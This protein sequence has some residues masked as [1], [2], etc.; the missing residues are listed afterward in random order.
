VLVSSR[1]EQKTHGFK[2]TETSEK[3]HVGVHLQ[4]NPK[5]GWIAERKIMRRGGLK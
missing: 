1:H 5:N 3:L 2:S 4:T